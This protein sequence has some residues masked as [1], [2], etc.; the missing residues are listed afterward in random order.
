M[1]A[2]IT[3]VAREAGVS[4][5]TVSRVINNEPNVSQ[6]TKDK[7]KAAAQALE[8]RPNLAAR[9]LA[10]SKSYLIALLYDI[11]SPGYISGIQRGAIQ[12]CRDGGYHLIVEP[13]ESGSADLLGIIESILGQLSVDGVILL[14]PLCDNADVV[15]LLARRNIAYV[16]VTPSAHHG[17]TPI[18]R[19]ENIRA[20]REMTEY[21][22]DL[23]HRD[24]GF[25]EGPAQYGSSALRFQGFR[26]AM[27]NA[28]LELRPEWIVKGNYTFK[29]GYDAA[30]RLLDTKPHPSAIFASNDDMA[31]GLISVMNQKG[32][33]V[34]R[35]ISVVGFDDTRIAEC[36]YPRLTTVRQPIEDMGRKAAELL[37][38]PEQYKAGRAVHNLKH[39]LIVR[40]STCAPD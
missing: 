15:N 1:K 35:D 17:D 30:M 18:V 10:S 33:S 8:Y 31:V 11:P 23:G 24:I 36:V 25:I 26:E 21:L 29:S 22:I 7:V 4:I 2:T 32:L 13:V 37:L 6:K 38:D 9:G 34:P 3:D 28:G 12:A 19:M 40:D 20:A 14:S 16:P 27:R 39:T 5:K